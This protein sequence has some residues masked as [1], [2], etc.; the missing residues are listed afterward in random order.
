MFVCDVLTCVCMSCFVVFLPSSAVHTRLPPCLSLSLHLSS[1]E[2]VVRHT[3]SRLF[4]SFFVLVFWAELLAK[5]RATHLNRRPHQSV[6]SLKEEWLEREGRVGMREG[7]GWAWPRKEQPDAAAQSSRLRLFWC[8]GIFCFVCRLPHT[9]VVHYHR[10]G[11]LLS[12]CRAVLPLAAVVY[13]QGR[14]RDR[15]GGPFASRKGC[16]SKGLPKGV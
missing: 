15:I 5:R 2:G 6:P 10:R 8:F 1:L 13:P 7:L 16:P 14:R 9:R 11:I 4:H 12:T 3:L